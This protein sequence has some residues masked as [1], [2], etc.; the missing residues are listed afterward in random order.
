MTVLSRW[1]GRFG[2]EP[3]RIWY[4]LLLLA[5]VGVFV[6]EPLGEHLKVA[7]GLLTLGSTTVLVLSIF[8]VGRTR[9]HFSIALGLLLPAVV[10]RLGFGDDPE[11]SS[12]LAG[13]VLATLLLGF[14]AGTL[15]GRIFRGGVVSWEKISG[16]VCVYMLMGFAW[17]TTFLICEER[18][19]EPSA[20]QGIEYSTESEE[21]RVEA[22]ERDFLRQQ[23]T[24]FSFVTLTTLGYGDITPTHPITRMLATLE[25]IVGQLF[26]VIMV[27][28][29]VAMQVAGG[30]ANES[31]P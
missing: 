27:A 23:L 10:L 25:A 26:L 28:R 7:H 20:F 14:V 18:L 11:T 9:L 29:L 31:L 5:L 4:H 15:A 3:P 6:L 30:G 2:G 21:Q 1:A 17:S 13:L 22:A 24:Y 16:A 8:V 19:Q 12:G